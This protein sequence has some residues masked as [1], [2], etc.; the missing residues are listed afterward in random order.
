[1]PVWEYHRL[2]NLG[3]VVVAGLSAWNYV[4][5][6]RVAP[7]RYVAANLAASAALLAVG[8]VRASRE[9]LGLRAG[10]GI[11][12]GGAGAA[13]VGLGAVAASRIPAT[14]RLFEDQRVSAE[15]V[16]YQTLVRIP[17][18]TVVLEEVAFRS[19]LPALLDGP[20]RARVSLG[21]G[22]LFGL[23]HIIPTLT[24]LDINGVH[25][26]ATR[27]TAVLIG[28]A[29]TAAAG[30]LFD[31]LRLRSGSVLAPMLVHW[32]A[33]AV[34]YAIAAKRQADAPE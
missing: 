33:N 4:I 28:G 20:D 18:G 6:R 29:A 1:M 5:N 25:E 2:M 8:S 30:L 9:Q 14:A 7:D 27:T 34:S 3:R 17:M 13:V 31:K 15:D 11:G 24:T 19:V 10:H 21:S 12:I 26:P 16:A 32:S 23:W 22:A